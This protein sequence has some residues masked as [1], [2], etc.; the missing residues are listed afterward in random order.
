MT[1]VNP[2]SVA[3]PANTLSGQV[4]KFVLG[5]IEDRER[6]RFSKS[7]RKAAEWSQLSSEQQG[8]LSKGN[9]AKIWRGIKKS[10]AQAR[11]LGKGIRRLARKP[12][13]VGQEA[14]PIT[15]QE[16]AREAFQRVASE[17][18][19]AWAGDLA[20][21]NWLNDKEQGTWISFLQTC[22]RRTA[23]LHL[24]DREWRYAIGRDVNA[25]L[26][27]PAID[28]WVRAMTRELVT[29][30]NRDRRLALVVAQLNV[31]SGLG[32]QKALVAVGR[33]MS[34]RL[35]WIA[36]TVVAMTLLGGGGIALLVLLVD[37]G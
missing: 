22:L 35:L 37:K 31:E 28:T 36:M 34:Q 1:P 16:G 5:Q 21:A 25:E 6:E 10:P 7:F 32:L 29:H 12:Q 20:Q 11:R 27:Q 8:A 19:E 3:G 33:E 23:N 15:E 17:L 24:R 30:W 9:W 4:L 2:F 18:T 14:N 26:T 13:Q